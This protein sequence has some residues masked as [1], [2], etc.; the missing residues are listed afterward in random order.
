MTGK[1]TSR[2]WCLV[3]SGASVTKDI[4]ILAFMD[5]PF[6]HEVWHT[7]APVLIVDACFRTEISTW[8]PP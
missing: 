8:P 6:A 3:G 2:T 4:S 7:I 1:T 5:S